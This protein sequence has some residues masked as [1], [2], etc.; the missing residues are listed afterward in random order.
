[1]VTTHSF[2]QALFGGWDSS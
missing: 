2:I 1:M